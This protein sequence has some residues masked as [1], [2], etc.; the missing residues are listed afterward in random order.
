MKKELFRW[1]IFVCIFVVEIV[2]VL[3]LDCG[4]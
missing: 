4:L 1:V 3:L 2:G